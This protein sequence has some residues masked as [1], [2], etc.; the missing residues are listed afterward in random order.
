MEDILCQGHGKPCFLKTGTKEGPNKGKSYYICSMGP[1]KQCNHIKQARLPVSRCLVH[2]GDIVELQALGTNPSTGEQKRY[3]RCSKYREMSKGWCG[4]VVISKVNLQGDALQRKPL[5]DCNGTQESQGGFNKQIMPKPQQQ[6]TGN[7]ARTEHVHPQ[8]KPASQPNKSGSTSVN[9]PT[10]ATTES[11]IRGDQSRGHVV[12]EGQRV[13]SNELRQHAETVHESRSTSQASAQKDK[14]LPKTVAELRSEMDELSESFSSQ[15]D[16]SGGED[17]FISSSSAE[18]PHQGLAV[19]KSTSGR[20]AAGYQPKELVQDSVGKQRGGSGDIVSARRL[21]EQRTV[22]AAGPGNDRGTSAG[23][24]KVIPKPSNQVSGSGKT[25]AASSQLSSSSGATV[26]SKPNAAPAAENAAAPA[27]NSLSKT[28]QTSLEAKPK[29]AQLASAK[30]PTVVDVIDL[31]SDDSVTL[32]EARTLPSS[33]NHATT[34]IPATRPVTLPMSSSASGQTSLFQSFGKV[35]SQKEQTAL[36]VQKDLQLKHQ[37]LRDLDKQKNVVKTVPLSMLPDKGA[38][39][40]QRVA[41]TESQLKEVEARL[42]RAKIDGLLPAQT[43]NGRFQP[44]SSL[45]GQPTQQQSYM[46]YQTASQPQ[47]LTLY[48]GRM[49]TVRQREVGAITKGAID[50]LHS[51]LQTCPTADA[52]A[53]DP[54]GLKVSL[55]TH[56][57]QALAWLVWREKQHPCGGILADDMGLGKTLTM[58][59]LA[60]WQ[61]QHSAAPPEKAEDSKTGDKGFITSQATLVVCPASL[62]SQWQKEVEQ[63]CAPGLLTTYLYHGT[64]RER[65]ARRLAKYDMVF[66]TY[67]IVRKELSF[68][69]AKE[70]GEE[71]V[72][73]GSDLPS[74]P[75]EHPLLLQIL[76]ERIILDEAHNI[77]NHK[78]QTAMAVCRLR[79]RARWAVTGTPIQNNLVDMYSLLRFLRCSPFDEYKVWKRQVDNNSKSGSN[80]LNVLV[81]S[82]LLRRTKDQ[83]NTATGKPLVALPDKSCHS[84]HI[85]LSADERRVYEKLFRESRS[86]VQNY[87]RFHEGKEKAQGSGVTSKTPALFTSTGSASVA[88][89]RAPGGAAGGA[90]RGTAQDQE[91]RMHASHILV[92]LLRLRQCCGHLS[93]LKEAVDTKSCEPEGI[94]LDLVGQM[95][96]MAIGDEEGEEMK[97]GDREER[98]ASKLSIFDKMM[99]STKIA[100]VLSTLADIRRKSPAGRPMKSVVVSQWTQMLDVMGAHLTAAGY[101]YWSIRGDVPPKKRAEALDDFNT[102]PRGREVMLVSLQA[103]GV[104]LNLIGGNHLFLLDMHWNPALEDQACDRIYRVG[105][106][107]NVSIHKFVCRNTIEERILE[108]QKSK[109]KLASDV[110]SGARSQSQKLSL[111][112]LRFL[113]GVN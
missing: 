56:Q 37:L 26:Q 62:M 74:S 101:R 53:E 86:K 43:L 48:G 33:H 105:Q 21:T 40:V 99:P 97:R 45:S 65:S 10:S 41:S 3:F 44:A 32:T 108:L 100:A 47:A 113:F 82:L 103:G 39:L 29:E 18:R 36:A 90:V 109:S 55:M 7:T 95:K 51:S 60:L 13:N 20:K 91:Q 75:A 19:P 78:S 69:S 83:K 24:T 106:T 77:K 1:G 54:S 31:T 16:I 38:K 4:S 64:N 30:Q 42:Q 80:R 28:H 104:G 107:N 11:R 49:T 71:P 8:N 98:I 72:K 22:P 27:V 68:L 5:K 76:W 112:D 87:I 84:H 57:R 67:E 35:T 93:L 34:V 52:E 111:A 85:E 46:A 63:R 110:L 73:D 6:R 96:E 88:T 59:S 50:K 9:D 14:P 81:K 79:A 61:K 70:K 25:A 58:I 102:E 89:G 15:M 2:D 92:L 66:T 94:D 12:Q 23:P 17:V